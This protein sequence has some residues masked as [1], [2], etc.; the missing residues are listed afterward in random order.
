M[1]I[2][3]MVWIQL[4]FI[5]CA[6]RFHQVIRL[7]TIYFFP[8]GIFLFIKYLRTTVA[9]RYILRAF[10]PNTYSEIRDRAWTGIVK[11]LPGQNISNRR[12]GKKPGPT[13]PVQ[14]GLPVFFLCYGL[15]AQ[16][17]VIR[18]ISLICHHAHYTEDYV[19]WRHANDQVPTSITESLFI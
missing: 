9:A 1:M 6:F 14:V 13:R 2:N 19:E 4:C 15:Y 18:N 3:F 16:P 8:S 17:Q 12:T 10:G 7:F 11:D 5:S